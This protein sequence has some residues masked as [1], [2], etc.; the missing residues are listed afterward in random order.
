MSLLI[1]VVVVY[2][3]SQTVH[4]HLF[5]ATPPRPLLLY[6]LASVFAEV[7]Y[8]IFILNGLMD[9]LTSPLRNMRKGRTWR[10]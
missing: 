7:G 2:G 1:A 5:R 8:K 9:R 3:F 6:V 4:Q 10:D